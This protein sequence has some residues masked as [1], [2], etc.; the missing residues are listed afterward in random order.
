MPCLLLALVFLFPVSGALQPGLALAQDTSTSAPLMTR[1]LSPEVMLIIEADGTILFRHLPTGEDLLQ[2]S[3]PVAEERRRFRT[4]EPAASPFLDLIS[5]GE[6]GG[7]R[8]FSAGADDDGDGV[9]DEDRRDGQDNDGDGLVDEDF[10]AIGHDMAVVDRPEGLGAVHL[11]SYRW[12]YPELQGAVF[13]SSSSSRADLA[14]LKVTTGGQCWVET[15]ITGVRHTTTGRPVAHRSHPFVTRLDVPTSAGHTRP[16]WLAVMV[17]GDRPGY[18][19]LGG[20]GGCSLDFPLS[21]DSLPLVFCVASSWLQLT[22]TLTQADLVYRGVTDPLTGRQAHWIVPGACPACRAGILPAFSFQTDE[23]Q[24]LVL[25]MKVD[26]GKAFQVDPDLFSLSGQALGSPREVTW[27]PAAG[28]SLPLNWGSMDTGRLLHHEG[29]L[30]NPYVRFGLLEGHG[31]EGTVEFAFARPAGLTLPPPD[32]E[33]ALQGVWLGGRTFSTA[34]AGGSAVPV[35]EVLQ[36]TLLESETASGEELADPTRVRQA[37]SMDQK[38]PPTLSPMLLEG[39]PNPF[40]DVIQ[41]RFRVP[42]TVGEAFA[43]DDVGDIPEHLDKDAPIPW[44]GGSPT[45]TVKIY[46]INGQ[47]L[48]T[49]YGGSVGVGEYSVQWNGSDAFGRQVASGTYFCKLQLDD[50]SVTRRLVYVR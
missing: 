43:W 27:I 23:P 20:D 35:P 50:W 15:D 39:W 31:A 48:V 2:A 40:H 5:E 6:P 10:A 16:L 4:R 49:L 28:S 41:V 7:M 22:T 33:A 36:G 42:T 46:N 44:S 17:L 26:K 24:R 38:R 32:G 9:Q 1:S 37:I 47:E 13:L 8:G 3:V 25:R 19:A 29:G 12:S 30:Q 34:A 14:A 11:E 21:T 45:A 18:L